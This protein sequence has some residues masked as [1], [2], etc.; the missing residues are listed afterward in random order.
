M[1][2][3]EKAVVPIKIVKRFEIKRTRKLWLYVDFLD[4]GDMVLNELYSEN[5]VI[6]EKE[7]FSYHVMMSIRGAD[8]VLALRDILNNEYPGD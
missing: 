8:S 7:P 4:N 3:E 2:N 5:D 6:S 1:E